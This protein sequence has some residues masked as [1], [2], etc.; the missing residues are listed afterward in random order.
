[1]RVS[2][3]IVWSDAKLSESQFNDARF[4]KGRATKGSTSVGVVA[5]VK[6][7]HAHHVVVVRGRRTP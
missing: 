7:G 4:A 3:V 1:M 5:D 2:S 6:L